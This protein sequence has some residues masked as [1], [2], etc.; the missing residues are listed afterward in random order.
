MSTTK[1]RPIKAL[2]SFRRMVAEA[3]LSLSNAVGT[4]LFNNP[5]FTAAPAPPVD[6]ATLKA[7]NDA[8][9]AAN[10]AALDRGKKAI[11]QR[12]HQ[13]EVR[14]GSSSLAAAMTLL[15]KRKLSS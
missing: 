13:K 15:V 3:V 2:T 14:N 9:A 10:A 11:A 7:A 8:L 1:H 5:N 4:D 12:Q 6:Q